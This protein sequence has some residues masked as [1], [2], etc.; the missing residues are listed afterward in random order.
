V[1]LLLMTI[2]SSVT[3]VSPP[4]QSRLADWYR[5]ADLLDAFAV[6]LPEGV[7][8]DVRAIGEAVLG[9]QAP[10]FKALLRIRDGVVRHLGVQTSAEIR[11]ADDGRERIDFFP[12]LSTHRDELILGED[13]RH[14]DVRISLLIEGGVHGPDRVVATTVVRSH[15]LVGRAY[16]LAIGPFHRLA[17]KSYL[18]RAAEA[19]FAVSA[20]S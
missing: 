2:N 6:Q 18:R 1:H 7:G 15:N 9:Q 16:L 17:V 3:E 10:W 11:Q 19:G 5:G 8:S 4:P 20:A 13:D 12:I 14:L